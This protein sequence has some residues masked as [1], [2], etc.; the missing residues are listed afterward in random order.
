MSAE[1]N[2]TPKIGI[3]SC[4][5]EEI[6]EGTI[7]RNAV[8]RVLES[9]RP[10]DAVTLCLP[11]F[12]A[13]NEGERNFARTHP[14]VTIDGCDKQCARWGTEKHGGPVARALVVT[15]ILGGEA[16]GCSRSLRGRTEADDQAT[17]VVADHIAAEIDTLL[18]EGVQP[19]MLEDPSGDVCACMK[20]TE[21]GGIEVKG[22]RVEIPALGHVFSRCAKDGVP[23]NENAGPV[24]L[25]QAKVFRYIAP[26]EEDEYSS[27]LAQAYRAYLGG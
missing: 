26:E 24:L 17:A 8:R 22:Q 1:M 25:E 4:S 18:G 16:V 3:I 14:V 10:H 27:A 20:P 11:L 12:L 5:G 13:G 2:K 7:S 9:L 6:P 19:E 21:T 23:G 15:D